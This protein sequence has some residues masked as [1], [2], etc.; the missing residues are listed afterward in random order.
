[1]MG[2]YMTII[3]FA[4]RLALNL[5]EITQINGYFTPSFGQNEEGI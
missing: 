4:G 2:N 3:A 5:G 1:M